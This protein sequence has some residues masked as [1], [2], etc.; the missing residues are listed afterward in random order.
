MFRSLK[1]ATSQNN[2][3]E[4]YELNNTSLRPVCRLSG[5]DKSLTELVF[6]PI[7]DYLLFSTGHDGLIKLWDT[8]AGGAC[9]QEYRGKHFN[10]MI[11]HHFLL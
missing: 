8:R 9:I 3:I 10:G 1:I 11:S 7:E 5:H 2:T 6:H 4:V